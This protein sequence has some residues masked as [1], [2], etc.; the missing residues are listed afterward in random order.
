[1]GVHFVKSTLVEDAQLDPARPEVL[2]YEPKDG[3]MRLLG[4]E[5]LVVADAWHATNKT[6]P[7]LLGQAFHYTGSPNRYGLPPFYALHVWAWHGN[8]HGIFT[9]WN[10]RVSCAEYAGNGQSSQK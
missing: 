6:P 1:M 5:F 7:T 4:A 10:L 2:L 3:R 8:P 9:D